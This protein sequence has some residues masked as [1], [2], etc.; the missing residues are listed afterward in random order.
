MRGQTLL[1]NQGHKELAE[2]FRYNY[3]DEMGIDN[4]IQVFEN[5]HESWRQNYCRAI[6]INIK[7]EKPM[8]STIANHRNP[9]KKL[10]LEKNGYF[11]AGMLA[12]TEIYLVKEFQKI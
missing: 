2:E 7:G 1:Y 4:G 11:L 3:E 9:L 10:I 5:S 6:D 12:A 8:D